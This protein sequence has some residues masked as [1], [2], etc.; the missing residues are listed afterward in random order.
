MSNVTMIEAAKGMTVG[1]D[2]GDRDA[3]VAMVNPKGEVVEEVR[4]KLTEPAVRSY[5]SRKPRC[6]VVLEAGTHSPWVTR[7][8][9]GLGHEVV[10]LDPR[11]VRLIA[12][13]R[14]KTDRIDARTLAELGRIGTWLAQT[15]THREEQTQLDLA[16]LRSRGIA[17]ESRTKLINHI[18][19]TVK[20]TGRRIRSCRTDVFHRR[21]PAD[22]PEELQET[23]LPLVLEVANLSHQIAAYNTRIEALIAQR[24]PDALRLL[25]VPGIGPVT[26]L[27][28]IL[29]LEHPG[30]FRRNRQVGKYVG[31]APGVRQSGRRRKELG[32][33]K[34]GDKE[35]RRLLL[36]ASHSIRT[37]ASADGDLRRWALAKGGTNKIARKKAAV[38]L[39]RKLAVLLLA[40]WRS[41]QDYRPFRLVATEVSA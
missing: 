7:L 11:K 36:Q 33:T 4:L 34:E 41:G 35:L 23:L 27:T 24:Y 6:R 37:H 28:F 16:L 18:R 31:L 15:V 25:K 30:R 17:V 14:Q 20:I 1:L 39:A 8:L 19:A 26:A 3:V 38:G 10:V 12:E 40:I 9:M 29:T 32:I 2:L 21:A 5:L 22:I 13:S